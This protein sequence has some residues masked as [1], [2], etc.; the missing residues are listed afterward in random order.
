MDNN[1]RAANPSWYSYC[2]TF[3][4]SQRDILYWRK[5]GL[6]GDLSP[7]DWFLVL[8]DMIDNRGSYGDIYAH[9]NGKVD[10]IMKAS[11]T[12]RCL[13]QALLSLRNP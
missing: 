9:N 13:G 6:L 8:S 2:L 5:D 4:E 1:Y 10:S 11:G 3:R 7:G 12:R